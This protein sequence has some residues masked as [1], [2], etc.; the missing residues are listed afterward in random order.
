MPVIKSAKKR[1]KQNR[2]RRARN[3]PVR[4][5]MKTIFK[6][7]LT[8]I[9]EGKADEAAKLMP[10]AYAII[11]KAAKKNIIHK[12]N[13]ANKKSRLARELNTLQAGG[14][15]AAEKEPAK[16]ATKKAEPKKEEKTEEK[17]G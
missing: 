17:E 8:A 12:R 4:S 3:F 1:M 11:D 15:K 10:L 7:V 9:R 5:E 14:G 13:A 2:V 16:K 6:K